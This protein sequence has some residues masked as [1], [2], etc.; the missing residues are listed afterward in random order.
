MLVARHSCMRRETANPKEAKRSSL[1]LL[2]AQPSHLS[3]SLRSRAPDREKERVVFY[4]GGGSPNTR[5]IDRSSRRRRR[6]CNC[7]AS[8]AAAAATIFH[9][10]ACLSLLMHLFSLLNNHSL[11]QGQTRTTS[12]LHCSSPSACSAVP[13]LLL[14]NYILAIRSFIINFPLWITTACYRIRRRSTPFY[15][16][17]LHA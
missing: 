13:N 14:I 1:P 5:S 10:A 17:H 4:S 6:H 9:A 8:A 3:L 11:N 2:Q 15:S 16:L 7:K 12:Y